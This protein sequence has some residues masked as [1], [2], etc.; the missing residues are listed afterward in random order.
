[1]AEQQVREAAASS[2][3]HA[4]PRCGAP[5]EPH[6]AY[7]LECGLRLPAMTGVVADLRRGWIRRFGWYPGDWIW[8]ALLTLLVAIAGIAIAIALTGG[9]GTKV[10]TFVAT[11]PRTRPAASVA[12]TTTPVRS[13]QQPT[14]HAATTTP[15]R[16]TTTTTTTVARVTTTIPTRTTPASKPTTTTAKPVATPPIVNGQV[17]WPHGVSGW[18]DVL[19]SYPTSG[20]RTAADTVAARAA[21]GGL[22]QVGVLDSSAYASLHAGY[23]VVFSGVYS[24]QAAAAASLAQ[25]HSRGFASAYARQISG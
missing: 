17:V 12:A 19:A 24:S 2:T 6:Q 8:T 23:Y 11:T 15:A 9:K 14:T 18:T 16:T 3:E 13:A 1:M 4:C 20:G 22:R 21:R 5:R 10:I 7:C 25:A